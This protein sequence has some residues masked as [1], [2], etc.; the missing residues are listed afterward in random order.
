MFQE[1][2]VFRGRLE[3]RPLASRF[4][5]VSKGF[6]VYNHRYT[7]TNSYRSWLF[8][9]LNYEI[10]EKTK[11]LAN[12]VLRKGAVIL[13]KKY[14]VNKVNVLLSDHTKFRKLDNEPSSRIIQLEDK[15]KRMLKHL[16]DND[17]ISLK[18]YNQLRASGSLPGILYGLPNVH[19]PDEPV[20]S[21]TDDV[22]MGSPLGPTLVYAL[23]FYHESEWISDYP[24][25]FKPLLYKRYVDD[26]FLLFNDVSH[27]NMFL[28]YVNSKHDN[29]SFSSEVEVNSSLSFLDIRL[30]H[31]HNT[32]KNSVYKKTTVTGVGLNYLMMFK[33]N[34]VRTL[35]HNCFQ[36]VQTGIL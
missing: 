19:K 23:S 10:R 25:H 28:N 20:Y 22:A 30:D 9:L 35:L 7:D 6:K 4:Q 31:D 29:I 14:Y 11:Q 12:T 32:F 33:V 3:Q 34:A 8:K 26:I 17:S 15:L 36:I 27:V 2:W 24:Y 1:E 21:Q 5:K 13:E 18:T 16:K